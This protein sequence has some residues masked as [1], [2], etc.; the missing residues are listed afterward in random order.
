M[1]T[2]SWNNFK[3]HSDI[4]QKWIHELEL[5][6]N[7]NYLN[8]KSYSDL[9]CTVFV[10]FFFFAL[11]DHAVL[12]ILPFSADN[13]TAKRKSQTVPLTDSRRKGIWNI[14]RSEQQ[15]LL[16]GSVRIHYIS[17]QTE[18]LSEKNLTTCCNNS[19]PWLKMLV[20][21][22]KNAP[23]HTKSSSK[24]VSKL[25]ACMLTKKSPLPKMDTHRDECLSELFTKKNNLINTF[26]HKSQLLNEHAVMVSTW[27]AMITHTHTHPRMGIAYNNIA[28]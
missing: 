25:L 8:L 15:N 27:L 20:L 13:D 11:F 23:V 12:F 14:S 3:W 7:D 1:K 16:L 6:C 9:H 22:K 21:C 4:S 28:L 24:H 10:G 18:S 17:I 26:R 19:A 5:L 2:H